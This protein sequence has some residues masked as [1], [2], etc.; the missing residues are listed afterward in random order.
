MKL[1]MEASGTKN[2]ELQYAARKASGVSSRMH[3]S[4]RRSSDIR[5]A[6]QGVRMSHSRLTPAIITLLGFATLSACDSGHELDAEMY[7]ALDDASDDALDLDI[8]SDLDTVEILDP[9]SEGQP[10]EL[11][12]MPEEEHIVTNC[13]IAD[14]T[15]LVA[16][17]NEMGTV[18]LQIVGVPWASDY[19]FD[20]T[21]VAFYDELGS[22]T[23]RTI[24]QNSLVASD[25]N[26]GW[27]SVTT[28]SGAT[29]KLQMLA[30]Y[31]NPTPGR[32]YRNVVRFAGNGF[33]CT[34]LIELRIPDCTHVGWWWN[35]SWPTP[36]YDGANC[37]VATPPPGQQSF[38][39]NNS[40]YVTPQNGN[41]C[42]M[43]GFDG[44]NC[45]VGSAPAGH[46]AFIWSGYFY[47]TP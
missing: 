8:P 29:F 21:P 2:G 47:F 43:G 13:L 36:S 40:W 46:G 20:V 7:D 3:S 12:A 14:Q 16:D 1:E 11:E 42:A 17:K 28:G 5:G 35:S 23:I 26:P 24:P 45:Y 37:Y 31:S 33:N 18:T 22:W 30:T 25:S 19:D 44:A 27:S 38:I 4:R 6:A 39:W 9:I 32:V 15:Y 41:Q 34:Q 10:G